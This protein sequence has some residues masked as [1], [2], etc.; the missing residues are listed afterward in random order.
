MHKVEHLLIITTK[1]TKSQ[2][3]SKK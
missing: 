1:N 3:T 2:I